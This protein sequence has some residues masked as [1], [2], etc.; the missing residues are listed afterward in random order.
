MVGA[1]LLARASQ[2]SPR[3]LT[4]RR[5]S[6]LGKGDIEDAVPFELRGFS[7]ATLFLLG[8]VALIV[9]SF[10][11]YFIFGAGGGSGIGGLTFIY[12]IPVLLL[13]AALSY[14]ELA[15][16]EV[17][18]APDA[19]GLF[20]KKATPTLEQIMSDVTRHRYG[21]DAHLDSS[22]KALGLTGSGRYPQ[23]KKVIVSKSSDGELEYTMLFESK[24]VPFTT[25]ND[26]MKKVACDRF[27]GPGVWSDIFKFSSKKRIAALRLTTGTRPQAEG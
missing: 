17:E 2:R 5:A 7:L 6:T 18:T 27:F 9:F 11:D 1:G 8:G 12:A 26:P 14:A 23:L 20:E 25:W 19:Q 15:P 3:S 21:D 24:D 10:A 13:G 4:R 22:L 16:V